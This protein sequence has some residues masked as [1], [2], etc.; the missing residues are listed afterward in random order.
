MVA[1]TTSHRPGRAT[2]GT[3]R[4]V[5]AALIATLALLGGCALP[6]DPEDSLERIR[7]GELLVGATEHLPWVDLSGDSPAGPEVDLVEAYAG[8]A[9]A[10]VIWVL[11]SEGELV[12]QLRDGEIDLI[13]GGFDDQTPWEKEAAVTRPYA[14][15]ADGT[16]RVLLTRQGENGFLFDLESFLLER[17][18]AAEASR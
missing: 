10:D 9:D 1:S 4:R 2:R 5:L 3:P 12:R 15:A 6:L 16:G 8:H 7:G 14:K 13:I 17:E 18:E 11:G